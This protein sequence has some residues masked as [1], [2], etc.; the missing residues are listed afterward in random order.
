MM[1]LY[2]KCKKCNYVCNATRFQQNFKNWTSGNYIIDEFI[3]NSQSKAINCTDVL[4]WVEY[5]RFEDI[6]YFAKGGFG[7]TYKA[8]WKDGPID[9]RS[10]DFENNQ[11]ERLTKSIPVVLK[12]LHDSQNITVKFFQYVRYFQFSM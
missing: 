10:W 4:E 6:K 8:I 3:Q 7:T 9:R 2:Y 1:V 11:W 5:D 12:C